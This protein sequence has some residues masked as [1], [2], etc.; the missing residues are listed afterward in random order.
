VKKSV[1]IVFSILLIHLIFSTSIFSGDVIVL[2]NG[3][4]L[5][6]VI[7]DFSV[8]IYTVVKAGKRMEVPESRIK[9]IVWAATPAELKEAYEK[10]II[11]EK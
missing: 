9:S 7:A 6:C 2:E 4:P 10:V 5:F 3:K 11:Y 8:G 1:L